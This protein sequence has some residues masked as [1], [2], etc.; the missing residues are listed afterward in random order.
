MMRRIIYQFALP[1]FVGTRL[2]ALIHR[3]LF[4]EQVTILMYHAVVRTPLP[5]YE[6]CFMEE[7]DFRRQMEYLQAN[8]DVLRLSEVV[9]RDRRK[10]RRPIAVITFDDG[11]ENNYEIAFPILKELS[12][13][14]TIF[15]TT[16]LIN[17]DE[18]LWFCR[19]NRAVA[20]TPLTKFEWH[21][22]Q[23]DL[24]GPK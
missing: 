13:P 8:F 15:L 14:T 9:R 20:L 17:S 11:F 12:L 10:V 19:L 2:P 4:K 3:K 7:K 18:T 23:F 22:C 24:S 21:R 1:A 5:V 16:G 6:Q